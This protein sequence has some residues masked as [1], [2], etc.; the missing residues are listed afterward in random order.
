MSHK[1]L[2]LNKFIVKLLIFYLDSSYFFKIKLI[3]SSLNYSLRPKI[4]ESLLLFFSLTP[5]IQYSSKWTDIGSILKIYSEK[6]ILTTS[7]TILA[8]VTNISHH[9]PL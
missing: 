4:K 8:Q 5:F 9:G 2:K 7:T 6:Y 3:P 1:H